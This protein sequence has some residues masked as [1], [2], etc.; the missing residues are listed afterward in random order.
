MFKKQSIAHS[1][2]SNAA[3]IEWPSP[4][5]AVFRPGPA[6]LSPDKSRLRKLQDEGKLDEDLISFELADHNE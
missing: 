3:P 4:Q 6:G 1:L 5:T 2:R